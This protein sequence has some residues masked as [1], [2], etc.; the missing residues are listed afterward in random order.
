M[1]VDLCHSKVLKGVY[2]SAARIQLSPVAPR[3]CSMRSGHTPET[4][5]SL[6]GLNRLR[7]ASGVFWHTA[8]IF[9]ACLPKHG[10]Y[11]TGGV[12]GGN[13]Y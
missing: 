4:A 7:V 13:Y 2:A 12:R 3:S 10:K 5:S 9:R 1:V 6:G 11:V 8:D